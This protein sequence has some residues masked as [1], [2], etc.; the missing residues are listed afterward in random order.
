M[1]EVKLRHRADW[2]VANWQLTFNTQ[3]RI[4][5]VLMSSSFRTVTTIVACTDMKS[6]FSSGILMA[7]RNLRD[8][9]VLP[10]FSLILAIKVLHC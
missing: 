4:F 10:R 6:Q 2:L 9:S 3:L 1:L 7:S 8:R 5:R